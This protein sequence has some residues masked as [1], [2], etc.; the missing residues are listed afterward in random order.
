MKSWLGAAIQFSSKNMVNC[1]RGLAYD[2]ALDGEVA[3]EGNK[4]LIAA[5]Y[6]TRPGGAV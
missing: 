2:P 6:L 5:V 1:S 4:A 3:V